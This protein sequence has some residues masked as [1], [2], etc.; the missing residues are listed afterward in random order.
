[1]KQDPYFDYSK[2]K[3]SVN[4]Q[5]NVQSVEKVLPPRQIPIKR[6]LNSPLAEGIVWAE[7]LSPPVSKRHGR[8]R[9]GI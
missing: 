3:V 2:S 7:I 4:N 1:M 6:V 9:R 5:E 8:G